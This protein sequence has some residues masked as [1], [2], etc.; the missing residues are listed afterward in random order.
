MRGLTLKDPALLKSIVPP[1]PLALYK[2]KVLAKSP[3]GF[4]MLDDPAGSTVADDLTA[5]NQ[6]LAQTGGVTFGAAG[7]LL[8]ATCVSMDGSNDQLSVAGQTNYWPSATNGVTVLV[9]WKGS[10]T[11]DNWASGTATQARG[12]IAANDSGT[13]KRYGIT[14]DANGKVRAFTKTSYLLTGPSETV[15]NDNA[16]HLLAL[17]QDANTYFS[18]LYVDLGAVEASNSTTSDAGQGTPAVRVGRNARATTN[19]YTP[20]LYQSPAIFP[21]VLTQSDI[22]EIYNAG[23]GL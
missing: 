17:T 12:V 8:G 19:A 22:E 15:V 1:S 16:W 10:V 6:D 14:I 3:S 20:G 21:A 18:K 4:W 7:G 2:S 5:F 13:L 23:M 9:W 11:G